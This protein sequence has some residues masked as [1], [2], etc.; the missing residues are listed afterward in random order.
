MDRKLRQM[1]SNMKRQKLFNTQLEDL[2]VEVLLNV[3]SF[4]EQPDL[5]R[6]G[7]VSKTLNSICLVQSC[8]QKIIIG[9]NT[10]PKKDTSANQSGEK[11][12]R[13]RLQNFMC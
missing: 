7:Q 3:L 13:P 8:Q 9:N 11:D 2:P 12:I 5:Y 10:R 4:L 1:E 6:V